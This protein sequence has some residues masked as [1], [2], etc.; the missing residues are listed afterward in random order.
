M[1]T[2]LIAII[3]SIVGVPLATLFG[4]LVKLAMEQ[5]T[6]TRLKARG[7]KSGKIVTNV[8]LGVKAAN[9][10]Y[11]AK[12]I[13]AE[14]RKGFAMSAAKVLCEV[15]KVEVTDEALDILTE[16]TVWDPEKPQPVPSPSGDDLPIGEP[17]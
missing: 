6:L 11:K 5:I 2:E 14:Q 15:D 12:R 9:Q 7:D 10:N 4:F 16:A 13:T 17:R 1:N 8:E 3:S